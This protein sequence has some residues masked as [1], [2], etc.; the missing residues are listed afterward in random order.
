MAEDISKDM[1]RALRRTRKG[2]KK[3]G[4]SRSSFEE[5]EDQDPERWK[6]ASRPPKRARRQESGDD[7]YDEIDE[8]LDE[9]DEFY[10]EFLEE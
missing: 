1:K 4:P 6:K 10:D 2:Q 8:M 9:H 3:Q 7:A 5:V